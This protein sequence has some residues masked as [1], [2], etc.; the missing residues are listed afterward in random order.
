MKSINDLFYTD[1]RTFIFNKLLITYAF[2]NKDL[3]LQII[4]NKKRYRT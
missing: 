2:R 4:D 3:Q 1:T